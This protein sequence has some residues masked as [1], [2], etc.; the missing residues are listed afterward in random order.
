M[1]SA[2][3]AVMVRIGPMSAVVVTVCEGVFCMALYVGFSMASTALLT[4]L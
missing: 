1:S 3:V 2:I 4:A